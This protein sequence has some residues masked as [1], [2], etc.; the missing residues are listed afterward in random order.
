MA[1]LFKYKFF[2]LGGENTIQIYADSEQGTLSI[3]KHI[4]DEVVRIQ[5]KFSRYD[6]N[7]IISSINNSAGQD[8]CYKLD[9]ETRSLFHYADSLYRQSNKLFDITSGVLRKAWN[10]KDKV[11]PREEDVKKLLP[12]VGW[13]KVVLKNSTISLPVKGMEID[14]GGI[15]KE[16]AVDRAANIL[17]DYQVKHA[18]INFAGDIKIIGKQPDNKFW[19][20][21]LIDPRKDGILPINIKMADISIAT[22]GDY[23]RFFEVNGRRYCHIIN[24]LTGYPTEDLQSVSVFHESCLIAGSFSTIT[25]LLGEKKGLEFLKD[26]KIPFIIINKVGNIIRNLI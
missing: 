18:L 12:Y 1:S 26:I 11:L 13:E 14:L 22:S 19:N 6:T 3:F 8:S 23:E 9:E 2:A 16:Y 21:G 17:E 7:S 4:E 5:N 10:F 15:G 25:M 24:P 20:I